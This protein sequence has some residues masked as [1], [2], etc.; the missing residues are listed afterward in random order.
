VTTPARDH[1]A[2]TPLGQRIAARI[3]RFGPMSLAEFMAT[4][5]S[6]PEHGYYMTGDPFGARGDFITAPEVSQMFG[7]LIGLWCAAT[8]QSMGAPE[9]VLLVE[10][11]PGRGTLMADALRAARMVPEFHR[12][13]RPHLVEISPVLRARQRETLAQV[14]GDRAVP[15][16]H[17]GLVSVPEDPLLLIANEFFDAL[18]IR[19]FEKRAQGWRE[20]LVVLAPD[21]G[22][23]VAP[24]QPN[25]L[26]AA[27]LPPELMDAPEDAV[28]EVSAAATAFAAEVGRRL[29]AHGGAALVIDYGHAAAR[30]LPGGAWHRRAGRCPARH[31]DPSP[32]RRRRGGAP[33]PH[34]SGGNGHAVQGSGADPFG[35]GTAG[36][37]R[38]NQ[39]L[40]NK[41]RPQVYTYYQ[42]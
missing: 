27:L 12:A 25:P 23:A 18:P 33:P 4:V 8:W 11:G 32:G 40:L 42:D 35:A 26:N 13:L 17:D 34:P 21:G 41:D 2:T 3:A 19:Q 15:T 14:A 28:A 10:L 39:Q 5:L 24:C 20:R 22:L 9:P 30:R 36:G 29:A 16:W 6:D 1:A 37:I 7:E 31:R 38:M